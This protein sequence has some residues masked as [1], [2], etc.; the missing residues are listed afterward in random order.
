MH[1]F[2]EQSPEV[3]TV[4][5]LQSTRRQSFLLSRLP[6]FSYT[7]MRIHTTLHPQNISYL[8]PNLYFMCTAICLQLAFKIADK[9]SAH[10][11]ARIELTVTYF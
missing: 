10:L 5:V 3:L 6:T 4:R 2:L 9:A 8:A 7:L 1:N 11:Q